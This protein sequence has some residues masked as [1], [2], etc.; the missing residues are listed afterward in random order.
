MTKTE[1][2]EKFKD[3]SIENLRLYISALTELLYSKIIAERQ[4]TCIKEDARQI[5][6]MEELE[7]LRGGV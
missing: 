2:Q 1:I 6:I 5:T 7:R 3:L 4:P